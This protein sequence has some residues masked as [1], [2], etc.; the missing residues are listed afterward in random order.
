MNFS[1]TNLKKQSGAVLFISLIFLLV[2]TLLTVSNLQNIVLQE[3]M[4]MAVREGHISLEVS[5]AGLKDAEAYIEN[6]TNT[7]GFS[8]TGT[9]GLYSISN[10]PADYFAST[11]WVAGKYLDAVTSIDGTTATYYIED[12]DEILLLEEDLSGIN[13]TGYGQTTGAGGVNVFKVVS[14]STGKSGSAERIVVIYYGKRL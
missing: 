3:K 7:G 12:L 4:T 5:E 10:G 11:N 9:G 6:L 1:N 8:S 13:M 2:M 14:R